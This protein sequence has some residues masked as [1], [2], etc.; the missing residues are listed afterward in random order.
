MAEPGISVDE[1][2]A[3]LPDGAY[4]SSAADVLELLQKQE[5]DDVLNVVN[6]D[7]DLAGALKKLAESEESGDNDALTEALETADIELNNVRNGLLAMLANVDLALGF[8][9]E[10]YEDVDEDGD[11]DGA[12]E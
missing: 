9:E 7:S 5:D 11:G 4:V 2:I 10:N 8:L 12:G 1:Q 3:A 6:E